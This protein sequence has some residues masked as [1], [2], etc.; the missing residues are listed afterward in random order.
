MSETEGGVIKT[1]VGV[2]PASTIGERKSNKEKT[3]LAS[4]HYLTWPSQG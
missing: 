1:N 4:A 3:S 2:S